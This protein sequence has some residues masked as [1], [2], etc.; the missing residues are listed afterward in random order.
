MPVFVSVCFLVSHCDTVNVSKSIFSPSN[1]ANLFHLPDYFDTN[2]V[3]LLDYLFEPLEM[4]K[5]TN[6]QRICPQ[7]ILACVD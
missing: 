5:N 6:M 2:C 1:R 3:S 4:F 7:V